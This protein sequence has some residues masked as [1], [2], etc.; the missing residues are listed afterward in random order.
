MGRLALSF[1]LLVAKNWN[2]DSSFSSESVE[3][4]RWFGGERAREAARYR[5]HQDV[6]TNSSEKIEVWNPRESIRSG[7]PGDIMAGALTLTGR[8]FV[9]DICRL[10]AAQK[11][12][13]VRGSVL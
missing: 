7:R 6:E 2:R 9:G 8:I 12:A 10:A 3:T 5:Q 4:K 11:G 1:A 13:M